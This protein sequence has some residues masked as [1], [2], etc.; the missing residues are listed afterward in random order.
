MRGKLRAA[1]A[2]QSSEGSVA[3]LA[4]GVL[5]LQGCDAEALHLPS[6]KITCNWQAFVL[7]SSPLQRHPVCYGVDTL[8]LSMKKNNKH[9]Q[10]HCSADSDFGVF[11]FW[12]WGIARL[13]GCTGCSAF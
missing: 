6:F 5:D 10:K 13:W 7:G 11:G 1:I 2:K 4:W 8:H 3:N 9:E 12:A